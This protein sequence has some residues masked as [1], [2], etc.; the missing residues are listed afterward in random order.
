MSGVRWHYSG[1]FNTKGSHLVIGQTSYSDRDDQLRWLFEAH[2]GIKAWEKQGFDARLRT[3]AEADALAERI[4]RALQRA[5]DRG[6]FAST[7]LAHN[8]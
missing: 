6:R 3:V 5:Y 8:A 1:A 7:S 4:A 2:A